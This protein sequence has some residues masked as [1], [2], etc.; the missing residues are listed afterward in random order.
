MSQPCCRKVTN[1]CIALLKIAYHFCSFTLRRHC[2]RACCT[3]SFLLTQHWLKMKTFFCQPCTT[4][5]DINASVRPRPKQSSEPRWR[6]MCPGRGEGLR[7][8]RDVEQGNSCGNCPFDP[9]ATPACDCNCSVCADPFT[10]S[11]R[12]RTPHAEGARTDQQDQADEPAEMW[13]TATATE[14][15]ESSPIATHA[16]SALG[17]HSATTGTA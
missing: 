2:Y 11:E 14:H 9:G 10:S 4:P 16:L 8:V 1:S 12:S 3:A 7:C 17:P 5:A 15:S 6:C 13:E